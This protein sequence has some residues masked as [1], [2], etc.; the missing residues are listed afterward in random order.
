MCYSGLTCLWYFTLLAVCQR[1]ACYH[2]GDMS[3]CYTN[4]VCGLSRMCMT[5][6]S[7]F[8]VHSF[9]SSC[10]SEMMLLRRLGMKYTSPRTR[11]SQAFALL[12]HDRDYHDTF[13]TLCRGMLLF[14]KRPW[15][16]CTCHTSVW[17][18]L[19]RFSK[20]C[21]ALPNSVL[22]PLHWPDQQTRLKCHPYW[23]TRAAT[24]PHKMGMLWAP[25]RC[26]SSREHSLT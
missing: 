25:T 12:F 8:I 1:L 13:Y 10:R 9:A 6:P 24:L 16:Y 2:F 20:S 19:P 7:I 5:L 14:H 21:W 18:M 11:W 17:G 4:I 15:P 3:D 26:S 22:Y 23:D